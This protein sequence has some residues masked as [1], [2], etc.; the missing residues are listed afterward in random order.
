MAKLLCPYCFTH[1]AGKEMAFR[2][3]NPTNACPQE[4]DEEMGRFLGTAAAPARRAFVPLSGFLDVQVR[5]SAACSCGYET[6]L[7]LCP[8]C[9]NEWP[10]SLEST[11]NVIIAI[12]GAKDV[13]KSQYVAVLINELMHNFGVRFSASLNAVDDRT[14]DRY[15]IDFRRYVYEEK[16]VVPSTQVRRV[17]P[18]IYRLAF[19]EG[20][21][22][23][24]LRVVTL[25]FF[26]TAGEN[27]ATTSALNAHNR[28][29]AKASG[30]LF[31]LD[32]LQ[33]PAVQGRLTGIRK[34]PLER[35]NPIDVI[36]RT[37]EVIRTVLDLDIHKKI[38]IPVALAFSKLD[39]VRP[40]LPAGS[41]AYKDSRHE[42]H[43]DLSDFEQMNETMRS[44]VAQWVGGGLEQLLKQ[45]FSNYAYFG[46]SALGGA[47]DDQGRIPGGVAPFR[48]EDPFLWLLYRLHVI[49]GSKRS[50]A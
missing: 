4:L 26:D 47:P 35:T 3:A 36:S 44:H 42:G 27:F 14:R 16:T 20:T 18:L 45:R 25:V 17:Y 13:G 48:V 37:D 8:H 7:K 21:F 9:H 28:Y 2:C 15:A 38:N 46:V 24:S 43:F 12:I 22:Y 39:A 1:F 5:R 29:M 11:D 50:S 34:F 40:I 49:S 6:R 32:P 23:K 41:V 30:I 33:I 31:L 10:A 19:E